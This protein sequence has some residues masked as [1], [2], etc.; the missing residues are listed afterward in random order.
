MLEYL[1]NCKVLHI[2]LNWEKVNQNDILKLKISFSKSN[3]DSVLL[4]NTWHLKDVSPQRNPA[5]FPQA[6]LHAKLFQSRPSLCSPMDCSPRFLGPWYSLGKNTGVG[7]HVLLQ[8]IFPIQGWNSSLLCFL[9]WQAGSLPLA[10]H[11]LPEEYT[12]ISLETLNVKLGIRN[13]KLTK[14]ILC[15]IFLTCLKCFHVTEF[16]CLNFGKLLKWD[17]I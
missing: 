2:I 1:E 4:G 5:L 16:N 3:I 17:R 10:P 8:E 14:I 9:H 13:N 6:C 12:F 15:L 11:G 7:C